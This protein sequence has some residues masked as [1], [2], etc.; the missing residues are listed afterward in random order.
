MCASKARFDIG[1]VSIPATTLDRTSVWVLGKGLSFVWRYPRKI[2]CPSGCRNLFAIQ[3]VNSAQMTAHGTR[4]YLTGTRNTQCDFPTSRSV[5]HNTW[6]KVM[7][8]FL[9]TFIGFTGSNIC[10]ARL[11]H[12]S[13]YSAG[14]ICALVP[15]KLLMRMRRSCNPCIWPRLYQ[16]A[17]HSVSSEEG[18]VDRKWC[19]DQLILK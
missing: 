13:Q 6:G 2:G 10:G 14:C 1:R 8:K 16:A 9:K 7:T 11:F 19:T 3:S 5:R 18:A 12:A 15:P 17:N 4:T